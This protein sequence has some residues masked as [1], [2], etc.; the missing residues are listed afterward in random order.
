[1]TTRVDVAAPAVPLPS[2]DLSAIVSAPPRSRRTLR[3]DMVA[4]LFVTVALA[5]AFYGTVAW[6]FNG[7]WRVVLHALHLVV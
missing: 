4:V 3:W 1:M 7:G 5:I 6:L 2:P